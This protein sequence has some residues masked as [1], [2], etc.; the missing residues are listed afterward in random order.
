[1]R[2]IAQSYI[3]AFCSCKMDVN[4]KYIYVFQTKPLQCADLVT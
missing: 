1:M 4:A 2:Q 3:D